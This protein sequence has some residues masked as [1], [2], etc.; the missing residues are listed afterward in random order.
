MDNNPQNPLSAG[1]R[2]GLEDCLKKALA[3]SSVKGIVVTGANGAFSAGA[4]ISEFATGLSGPPLPVVIA[5]LEGSEKPV[6][7]AIDGVALGGGCEVTLG[8]HYR[9]ASERSMVGLPEVNLGLLPGAGGTQRLPRLIGVAA[10]IDFMCTGKPA[11]AAAAAKV[12]IFDQVVPGDYAAVLQA[13]VELA[14]RSVTAKDLAERRLC[15]RSAS[16]TTGSLEAL[17]KEKREHFDKLRKGEIAP[18]AIIRC[19]EA[20]AQKNFQEGMKVEGKEFGKLLM[21]EQSKALQY[22]FFAERACSKVPDVKA[23]PSPLNSI[24]IVGAGLM[25]GGIA[26]C[27]AEAGMKV[28]LLD[29]DEKNLAR[30]IEKIKQNYARSV[31]R[32]SKSQAKVDK[33]LSLIRPASEYSALSDVDIVV[34][35]VYENMDLKKKIF[36]SLDAVCKPGCIMATNTSGLN[37]DEIAAATKRPADVIGCHFFSPANVMKLLENVRGTQTSETTIATAMAL[38]KKIGKVTCLVGNCHGFVANRVMWQSGFMNL[39]GSGLLPH[40]IDDAAEAFGM[41]MG[42]ASVADLV[43]LDLMGR[44]RVRMK[45]ASPETVVHD[46]LYAAG[47]YGQKT[48]KGYWLWSPSRSRDPEAEAIIEGVWKNR[49]VTKKA[50]NAEEIIE[51][52]YLPVVNEG[53][54]CLEEGMAMRAS[55]IDVCCVFGF[56]WPRYRGGPMQWASSVGLP[57]VLKKLE[58]S[59]LEPAPLLRECVKNNWSL[60]SKGFGQRVSEAWAAKWTT[61]S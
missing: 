58:D 31:Q 27:C 21:G 42:P 26:M 13:A 29:I 4:D 55:D 60:R 57:K 61:A 30:G 39:V 23:A 53:F 49:G 25:G 37:I 28:V 7:A 33:Y 16:C 20:A 34:E 45:V 48:N 46:A 41:K 10:S 43:G 47:R 17:L 11:Q 6:V 36:T 54:K 44:E 51:E 3:D 12:G 52:L 56:G 2:T 8:C 19:A 59:K 32:K 35:A 1:V 40:E 9:V 22:M 18:Q 15:S 38:G 14:A 5:A 24:G 50:A